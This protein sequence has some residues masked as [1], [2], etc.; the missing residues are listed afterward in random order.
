MMSQERRMK[1]HS[2]RWA[3]SLALPVVEH[4]FH[5]SHPPVLKIRGRLKFEKPYK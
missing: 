2:G 5:Q 1:R 4:E 3:V